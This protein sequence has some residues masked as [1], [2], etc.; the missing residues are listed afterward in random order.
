M[1]HLT[2]WE[3]FA[4]FYVDDGY[5]ALRDAEFLQEALNVLVKTFKCI[6]LATNMKKTPAMVCTLGKIRLQLLTDS[7]KCLREGGTAGEESK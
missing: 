4:I 6:G 5:I 1:R 7:Y 2:T 3:V